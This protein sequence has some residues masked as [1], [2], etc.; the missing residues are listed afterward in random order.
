M[1]QFQFQLLIQTERMVQESDNQGQ[2]DGWQGSDL[3]G[4][5]ASS[6]F[7]GTTVYLDEEGDQVQYPKPILADWFGL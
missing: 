3:E 6:K 2:C 1:G 7:W 4:M 5:E